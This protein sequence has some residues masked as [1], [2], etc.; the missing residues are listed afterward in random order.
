MQCTSTGYQLDTCNIIFC[1]ELHLRVHGEIEVVFQLQHGTSL[2]AGENSLS[3]Q[4]VAFDM[5]LQ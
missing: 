4:M 5:I 2:K 3:V 1:L